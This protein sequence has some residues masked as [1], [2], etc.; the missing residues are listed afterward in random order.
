MTTGSAFTNL[1]C[2][3]FFTMA[4]FFVYFHPFTTARSLR[5]A[6]LDEVTFTLVAE[7]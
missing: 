3:R 4:A 6:L 1:Y 2:E 7:F 5:Y